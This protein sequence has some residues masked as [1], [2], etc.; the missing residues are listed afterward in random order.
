MIKEFE[1]LKFKGK[2]IIFVQNLAIEKFLIIVLKIIEFSVVSKFTTET[3][4][5][6]INLTEVNEI[7][8]KNNTL[9]DPLGNSF[10]F[11]HF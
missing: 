4:V 8:P 1:S 10:F 6:I 3:V 9:F 5:F 11:L 7:Y 2:F